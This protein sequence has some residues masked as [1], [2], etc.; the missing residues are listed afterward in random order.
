MNKGF[1]GISFP[2]RF[3]SSGGVATSTTAP[4]DLSHIEESIEQIIRTSI[5]ERVM[6]VE[7]GNEAFRLLFENL[8]DETNRG[9]ITMFITDAIE[10]WDKR[11]KVNMVDIITEETNI[12]FNI[13]IYVQKYLTTQVVSISIKSGGMV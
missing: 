6:E 5:G 11:V 8:D 2:F 1:K 4:N 13:T 7:F 12:V 3:N 10:R 9:I